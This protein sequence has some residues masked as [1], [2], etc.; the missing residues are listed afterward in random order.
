[1]SRRMGKPINCICENKGEADQCLC[2]HYTDSTIH[3]LSKSK[4]QNFQPLTIFCDCTA[5]FVPDLVGTQIVGFLTHR[6]IYI[7]VCMYLMMYKKLTLHS[8][9]NSTSTVMVKWQDLCHLFEL[10]KWMFP[11]FSKNS[12]GTYFSAS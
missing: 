11:A 2:F 8:I 12:G 5:W 7:I 1:M 3:L 6:L 9:H 4:I 10:C